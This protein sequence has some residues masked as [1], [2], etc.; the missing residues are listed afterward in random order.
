MKGKSTI[1]FSTV[2][3]TWS[4]SLG[5]AAAA[6]SII[7][8]FVMVF[9]TVMS[10]YLMMFF[11]S[12]RDIIQDEYTSSQNRYYDAVTINSRL[13]SSIAYLSQ[14]IQ[15][16]NQLIA[17]SD[18]YSK[19]FGK[20]KA[21]DIFAEIA[22]VNYP[23]NEPAPLVDRELIKAF[24]AATNKLELMHQLPSGSPLPDY[25]Y[26]SSGYG[27]RRHPVTFIRQ[28]HAGIDMPLRIGDNVYST[29]EGTVSFVG[30]KI[31]YGRSVI[32]RHRF[33]FSTMYAHL[34][35]ILVKR[36]DV[37]TKGQHIAEGGN[38][39]ISTGPHLHYEILYLGRALNPSYFY[40][41]NLSNF[42]IV[43]TKYKSIKW[44]QIIT[45]LQKGQQDQE[46]LSSLRVLN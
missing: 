11:S 21:N 39:G 32:V 30:T 37:V 6:A 15:N 25:S 19:I 14:Q 46:Q 44:D 22:T 43:F 17:R 24:D 9:G 29:A 33:G 16:K 41:W 18:I 28:F 13:E 36:G 38:T 1:T 8:A 31:G 34:D 10:F 20:R 45:A 12:Q 3:K 23:L 2:R 26:V 35:K 27:F 5:R 7:I 40:D 4:I 42:D